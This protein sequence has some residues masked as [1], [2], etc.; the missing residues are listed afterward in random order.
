[1]WK[2]CCNVLV[3]R[4]SRNI[5]RRDL[6]GSHRCV[7]RKDSGTLLG[8][9]YLAAISNS[10]E[11]AAGNPGCALQV[12]VILWKAS[13]QVNTKVATKVWRPVHLNGR[14]LF[15]RRAVDIHRSR[16]CR[17]H[18]G[19]RSGS[20]GL[21]SHSSFEPANLSKRRHKFKKK[22]TSKQHAH[23]LP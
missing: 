12:V 17:S 19:N 2:V 18:A 5:L 11:C 21:L 8:I 4:M 1:M 14:C 20:C 23:A 10:S 16:S 3:S 22:P 6:E 13:V 7:L 9:N 15:L